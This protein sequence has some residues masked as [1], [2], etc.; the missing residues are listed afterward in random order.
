MRARTLL[1]ALTLRK[2]VLLLAA[3]LIAWSWYMQK[4]APVAAPEVQ[5]IEYLWA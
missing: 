4:P 2:C 3:L 5:P 1:K